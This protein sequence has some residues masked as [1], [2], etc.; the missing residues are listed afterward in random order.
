MSRGFTDAR[1]LGGLGRTARATIAL[2]AAGT[3]GNV[4]R[5]RQGRSRQPATAGTGTR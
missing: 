5:E 3:P 4:Q 2:A 1:S